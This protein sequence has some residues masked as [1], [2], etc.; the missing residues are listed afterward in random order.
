MAC[1][2][3]AILVLA[4][5]KL[6]RQLEFT[7]KPVTDAA[8]IWQLMQHDVAWKRMRWFTLAV[9]APWPYCLWRS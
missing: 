6:F 9:A 7:D 4:I 1:A 8:V 3:L 2:A 5:D